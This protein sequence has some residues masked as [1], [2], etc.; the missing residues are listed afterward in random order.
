[1]STNSFDD[2]LLRLRSKFLTSC[3]ERLDVISLAATDLKA[4]PTNTAALESIRRECHKLAGLS[5]SIGFPA[6]GDLAEHIDIS[7]KEGQVGWVDLGPKLEELMASL[8]DL[9]E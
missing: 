5:G 8:K 7:L 4:E 1:M 2:A 3:Q 6:I 9:N